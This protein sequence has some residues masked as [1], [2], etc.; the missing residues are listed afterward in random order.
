MWLIGPVLKFQNIM[1]KILGQ[2]FLKQVFSCEHHFYRTPSDNWFCKFKLLLVFSFS[3][4]L[5]LWVSSA[6][7]PQMSLRY[8]IKLNNNC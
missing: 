1:T 2:N 4:T 3:G 8:K 7:L 6:F 5:K